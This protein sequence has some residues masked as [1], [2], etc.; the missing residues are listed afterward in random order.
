MGRGEVGL[1]QVKA[2]GSNSGSVIV[3]IGIGKWQ[4]QNPGGED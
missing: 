4:L 3:V 2:Q 1:L